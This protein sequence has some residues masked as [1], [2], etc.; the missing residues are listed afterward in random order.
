MG[1]RQRFL[2]WVPYQGLGHPLFSH[3]PFHDGN[4]IGHIRGP[5]PAS[6]NSGYGQRKRSIY[7]ESLFGKGEER[8][9]ADIWKETGPIWPGLSGTI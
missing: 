2:G 1:A 7:P 3:P 8:L 6:L 9:P 5:G 4:L